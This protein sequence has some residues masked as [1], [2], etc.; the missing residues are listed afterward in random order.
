MN[1]NIYLPTRGRD[2]QLTLE[3]LPLGILERVIIVVN[4]DEVDRGRALA[5]AWPVQGYIVAPK[6]VDHIAKAWQFILDGAK[7][8]FFIM[9]DDL[10]FMRRGA[11]RK[12]AEGYK[13][14]KIEGE[15]ADSEFYA[16]FATMEK[17]LDDAAMTGL[18][19]RPFCWRTKTEY[20]DFTRHTQVYG[21]DAKKLK[22]VDANFVGKW[23]LAQSD[24]HMQLQLIYHGYITRCLNLYCSDQAGSGAVGGASLYRT[25][26]A[27]RA[28]AL[29]LAQTWPQV[30]TAVERTTKGSFGG[31]TR[32][33]VRVQWSKAAKLA[34]DGMLEM[35]HVPWTSGS[36]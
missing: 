8:K 26:E 25:M 24:F 10:R 19:T 3:Q 1:A 12:G 11:R 2:R 31:G 9:D 21:Y 34:E 32:T 35:V 20:T 22:K 29:W 36:N 13:L 18:S 27:L 17:Y 14:P 23:P 30:V 28:S 4:H 5:K 7:G 6:K 16:A 15:K 33:D